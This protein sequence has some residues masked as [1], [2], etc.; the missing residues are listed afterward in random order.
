MNRLA[1][2]VLAVL[3]S[4]ATASAHAEPWLKIVKSESGFLFQFQNNGEPFSVDVPGSTIDTA[5]DRGRAFATID[6]VTFQVFLTERAAKHGLTALD[7]FVAEEKTFAEQAGAKLQVTSNCEQ[8]LR[9]HR[10]WR[11]EMPN[12]AV[13]L[14]LAAT[15]RSSIFL[16]TAGAVPADEDRAR[17]M[18][19]AACDSLK[20]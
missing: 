4:A 7:V 1:L 8:L 3:I 9:N 20:A 17:A 18:F 10:E 2:F 15:L 16:M 19:T 11:V 14:Y 12:G 5:E 6:H 13:S